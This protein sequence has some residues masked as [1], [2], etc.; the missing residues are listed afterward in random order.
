M[1]FLDKTGLAHLWNQII[2]RL[3]GKANIEDVNEAKT[4]AT[5]AETVANQANAAVAGKAPQ[6]LYGTSD[7][8]AGVS[9]LEHG[10]LYFVYE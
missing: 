7:L 1:P 5:N 3:N 4:Q 6:Y 8:E 9:E 2:A 10:V